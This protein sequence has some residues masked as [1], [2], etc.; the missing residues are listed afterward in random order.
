MKIVQ[1]LI[2]M[3]NTT[4]LIL[5]IATNTFL[6]SFFSFGQIVC[7]NCYDQN[8]SISNGVTNLIMNGGF[9]NT[10]CLQGSSDCF[11][12][13]STS[14]NCDIADWTCVGGGLLTYSSVFDS[15]LSIIP[16]GS[17]AVYFGN[18]YSNVCSPAMFD[19]SC[20]NYNSCMVSGIPPGYPYSDPANYGD[21]AG[22]S[23]E[24]TVSGLI[25]GQTYVLEFWAGGESY[26]GMFIDA[27]VFAVDV[28]FGKT[29]LRC[30]PT[31]PSSTD[32][33]TTYV[34]QFVATSAT[35]TIK[36]T[37]WGHMCLS[38]TELIIDNVRLYT[39]EELP[40]FIPH[41]SVGVHELSGNPS[42]A[43][44]PNP[45]AAELNIHSTCNEIAEINIYDLT[46]RRIIQRQF[47]NTTSL[48]TA[49]LDKGI[50]FYEILVNN[51][52]TTTGKVVK[53]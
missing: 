2:K 51:K 34:I 32:V 42:F 22:V 9:E 50:Y 46:S 48:N 3:K 45:I 43:I 1:K 8:D 12:P 27:G 4:A 47:R 28:G 25:S 44:F 33:G 49:E 16:Q 41:C 6:N 10:T 21:T 29:F 23:L 39:I 5:L 26:L 36:F 7:I 19:T 35:H 31:R 52:L 24:Q 20:L 40:V 30:R 37:N 14:Y 15:T 11:C 13:N 38:C 18:A 53:E 17:K